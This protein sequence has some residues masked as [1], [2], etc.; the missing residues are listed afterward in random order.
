M[1]DLTILLVQADMA[2][3][4]PKSNL[5]N[6]DP[7]LS[8]TSNQ[9]DLIV[10]SEMFSTGFSMNVEKCAEGPNGFTMQW[11][12]RKAS[13]LNCV[14]A[15]SVLIREGGRYYNRFVWMNP[16]GSYQEYNKRHLFSM[17]GENQT[18]TAGRN[19]TIVE[20]RGWKILLQV[21]Y[22]LRF[23]V[24]SKNE[25]IDG[26]HAYDA[27][28]Y[29]ANWPEIRKQAYQCLLPARAIEN[30]SYVLWVNRIGL[31]GKKI[32]HSGDSGVYDPHGNLISFANPHKDELL[33]SKLSASEL[34]NSR[35]KFKIGPDWDSFQII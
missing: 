21:C 1:Q 22:D 34:L 29:I 30:Q 14:V 7:K 25:F 19:K 15:G 20:Y 17:A 12:K 6:L 27:I 4:D 28:I 11:M 24:W 26:A 13:D 9:P 33:Y 8:K 35:K 5:K 3:E 23:P 18:M 2:W 32:A 10:L 31:D 16:D